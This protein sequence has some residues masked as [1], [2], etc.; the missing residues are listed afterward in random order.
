[1]TPKSP[2]FDLIISRCSNRPRIFTARTVVDLNDCFVGSRRK[3]VYA[4]SPGSDGGSPYL[5]SFLQW[6]FSRWFGDFRLN[7]RASASGCLGWSW[8]CVGRNSSAARTTLRASE[9]GIL[10]KAFFPSYCYF[11]GR[12]RSDCMLKTVTY[13]R[14]SGK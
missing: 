9:P 5:F 3:R 6:T 1:M 12:P 2:R 10:L 4:K 7:R 14:M 11:A 8:K 13:H